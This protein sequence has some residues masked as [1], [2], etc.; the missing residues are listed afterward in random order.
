MNILNA[1]V[2]LLGLS[3]GAS[4]WWSFPNGKCYDRA[5]ESNPYNLKLITQTGIDQNTTRYCYD[6]NVKRCK[7]TKYKCCSVL[8]ENLPK[9][10]FKTKRRCAKAV[11]EVTVGGK[12]KK[13]GVYFDEY[14]TH[15][16]LRVTA[17]VG[18]NTTVPPEA[19]RLCITLKRPCHTMKTFCGAN[20]NCK[21]AAWEVE[22][23][24]CCPTCS[25]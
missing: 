7:D 1:L 19:R 9:I 6:L 21:Y 16:E 4:A 10:V 25:L 11:V 23:H 8:S 15:S 17:L 2:A 20:K 22:K 12:P 18:L 5:C 14:T 24:E 3:S 13:G